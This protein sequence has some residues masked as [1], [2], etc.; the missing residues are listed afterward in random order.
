MDTQA[1]SNSQ[2]P[3]VKPES[4]S[5][6]VDNAKAV[7]VALI[8]ILG[9]VASAYLLLQ[10]GTAIVHGQPF[11]EANWVFWVA[12]AFSMFGLAFNSIELRRRSKRLANP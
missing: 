6:S 12:V 2:L 10:Y 8:S 5:I 11:P 9:I 3:L 7:Y 4:V 1:E